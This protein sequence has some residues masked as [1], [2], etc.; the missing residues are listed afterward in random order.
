MSI[1]S[2]RMVWFTISKY[3]GGYYISMYYDNGYNKASG[4]DL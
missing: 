4:E 2:N 1:Y 3:Y